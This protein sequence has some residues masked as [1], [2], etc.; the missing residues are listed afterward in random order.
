MLKLTKLKIFS[1]KIFSFSSKIFIFYLPFI[2]FFLYKF[3]KFIYFPLIFIK[4]KFLTY[5]NLK[6][7]NF[8]YS[9]FIQS[10]NMVL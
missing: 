2:N 8:F 9:I 4:I 7:K 3:K 5:I 6:K 1:K 10:I